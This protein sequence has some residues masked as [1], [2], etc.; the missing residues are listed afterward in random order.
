MNNY[1]EVYK[2]KRE[3]YESLPDELSSL[4]NNYSVDAI[5]ENPDQNLILFEDS[6]CQEMLEF[7]LHESNDAKED[8]Q[9]VNNRAKSTSQESSTWICARCQKDIRIG[10]EEWAQFWMK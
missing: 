8:I 6:N 2:Y 5:S 9:S 3:H 10:E 4:N 1:E 7:Q